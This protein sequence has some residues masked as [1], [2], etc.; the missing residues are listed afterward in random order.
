MKNMSF[1]IMAA[2]LL[3]LATYVTLSANSNNAQ[4]IP[5][6]TKGY[7]LGPEDTLEISVWKDE[8]LTKQV[9]V[10][11]DG[12]ISFPLIGEVQASGRT[13]DD[14]RQEIVKKINEYLPDPVVTV[15]VFGINSYKIYI[16]G[17]VN[18]PGTYTLGKA[19]NVMQALSMA[20]GFSP[21]AD[22]N[23]IGI[24]REEN[25]NQVRIKFNYEDVVKGKKLEQNIYLRSGDV[26][27][28]P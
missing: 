12:K 9:V 24:L 2:T 22:L 1:C 17:K 26:I 21:F 18:K 5:Q 8:A 13:V 3:V 28:V 7:L 11:P 15:M 27:V 23:D 6:N 19:V 10:R 4:E 14:L 20:G 16:I 25:G